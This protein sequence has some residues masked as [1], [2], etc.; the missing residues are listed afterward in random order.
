MYFPFTLPTTAAAWLRL[1]RGKLR[2]IPRTDLGRPPSDPIIGLFR[3]S[4]SSGNTNDGLYALQRS[5][6]PEEDTA[7]TVGRT[8]SQRVGYV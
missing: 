8:Y 3:L 4:R 6:N 5:R 7:R 2:S 1:S